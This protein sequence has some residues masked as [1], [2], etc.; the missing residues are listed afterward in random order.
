MIRKTIYFS[1]LH[2]ILIVTVGLSSCVTTK[3]AD[4][5]DQDDDVY[6]SVAQAKEA[7]P[8]VYANEPVA[9]DQDYVTEDEL[10]GDR[11]NGLGYGTDYTSRFNRFRRFSPYLGYYNSLYGF[12]Y[13][14]P[15][16]NG[17]YYPYN[18]Y[19]N[20]PFVGLN[21]SFGSGFFYDNPWRSYGFGYGSS[22]W[23]P[24]SYYNTWNPY[25]MRGGLYNRGFYSGIYSSPAFSAPNYRSRP[26]RAVDNLGIDR[27]SVIG[28]PGGVIIKDANGNVIQS[29]GRAERYGDEIR[30]NPSGNRTSTSRPQSGT[31]PARVNQTPPQRVSQPERIYSAPRDNGSSSRGGSSSPSNGGGS[32]GGARPSR[33]N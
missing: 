6:Y 22:F 24:Y 23:G 9:K 2:A 8:V 26:N 29:R 10:Y 15:F 12:N 19:L 20:G 4:L 11:Y 33:G 21:L 13:Y 32:S 3:T 1:A 31:R 18:S 28:N 16:F 27:G 30:N 5:I 17:A 14:D 7:A 25:G